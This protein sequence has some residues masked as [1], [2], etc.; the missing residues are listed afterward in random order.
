MKRN[1]GGRYKIFKYQYISVLQLTHLHFQIIVSD[2]DESVQLVF[3]SLFHHTT[4]LN[5]TL[6][7]SS[8]SLISS[9]S[10]LLSHFLISSVFIFA[11]LTRYFF[12]IFY[13]TFLQSAVCFYFPLFCYMTLTRPRAGKRKC[14]RIRH[15][16]G[17]LVC[18]NN[19]SSCNWKQ[20]CV[21]D[22]VN[23]KRSLDRFD[24]AGI[25]NK[26]ESATIR[27]SWK[28]IVKRKEKR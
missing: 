8:L 9:C 26:S 24:F 12:P 5:S 1:S 11:L 2:A 15:N 18:S 23:P 25:H 4:C 6:I 20:A 21:A 28:I 7:T 16:F 19:V 13:K 17:W 10:L 14:P 27:K 22:F 3:P